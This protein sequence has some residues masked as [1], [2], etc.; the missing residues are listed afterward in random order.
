MKT[1]R[2]LK[3]EARR[4]YKRQWKKK[5]GLG[6]RGSSTAGSTKRDDTCQATRQDKFFAKYS[7]AHRVNGYA[8]WCDAQRKKR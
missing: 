6:P 5:S 7:R 8:E 4:E 1:R 3:E 2:E